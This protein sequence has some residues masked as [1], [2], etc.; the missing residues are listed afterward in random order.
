MREAHA[1]SRHL[2][3]IRGADVGSVGTQISVAEIV[4]V[5]QD[6][7]GLGRRARLRG[8]GERQSGGG[9]GRFQE[10]T[11]ISGN[12]LKQLTPTLIHPEVLKDTAEHDLLTNSRVLKG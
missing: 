2:I 6:D 5:D 3:E 4:A 10:S 7:V 8:G 1:F 11:P 12:S 9:G